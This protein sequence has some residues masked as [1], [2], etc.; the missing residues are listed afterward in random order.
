MPYTEHRSIG[1]F[2]GDQFD[3]TRWKPRVPTAAFLNAQADDNFWAARRVL[4]FS[5]AMIRAIVKA[6]QYSDPAAEAYLADVLIKRRDKIG[7]A[8]VPVINPIV[9]PVLD[10][11]ALTFGNAAVQAGIS[12]APG[13]GYRAEWFAFDNATGASTPL[14]ASSTTLTRM[15][16]PGPLRTGVGG[17]VRIDVS[18]VNPPHPS[19]TVPVKIYFKRMPDGWRLVGLER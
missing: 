16:P 1:R 2:E 15:D 11:S 12:Q 13:G 5:D 9:D 3:P 17:F 6:G 18:A 10:S 8:Y 14:G 7:R 4:A 19:W